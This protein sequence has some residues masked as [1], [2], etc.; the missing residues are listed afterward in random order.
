MGPDDRPPW[1]TPVAALGIGGGDGEVVAFLGHRE[2][3]LRRP[4]REL[5]GAGGAQCRGLADDLT[6]GQRTADDG[7]EDVRLR[8]QRADAELERQ[9][10][11]G[12]T[13]P[14]PALEIKTVTGLRPQW[15]LR[16][17]RRDPR[18]I[19]RWEACYHS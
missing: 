14:S 15:V 2:V 3:L 8:R 19:V 7:V 11:R 10:G 16:A 17:S 13:V 1:C 12:L 9:T 5:S 4:D 18:H 6:G